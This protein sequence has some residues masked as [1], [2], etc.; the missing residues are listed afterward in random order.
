LIL[1][2]QRSLKFIEERLQ[3]ILKSSLSSAQK[4][5]AMKWMAFGRVRFLSAA[6]PFTKIFIDECTMMLKETVRKIFRLP[7]GTLRA[8]FYTQIQDG[9]LGLPDLWESLTLQKIRFWSDCMSRINVIQQ[10]LSISVFQE[11]RY[12]KIPI[13]DKPV[14]KGF[15]QWMC[16]AP[17]ER[18]SYFFNWETVDHDKDQSSFLYKRH[19]PG[20]WYW[21][22][23]APH[24][25]K[26]KLSICFT[27]ARYGATE[28]QG[29]R[30]PSKGLLLAHP[31]YQRAAFQNT[32]INGKVVDGLLQKMKTSMLDEKFKELLRIPTDKE[33]REHPM[34]GF[35]GDL[36]RSLHMTATKRR[37]QLKPGADLLRHWKP[38]MSDNTVNLMVKA[39]LNLLGNALYS[40][41]YKMN[42][43]PTCPR[44]G[45]HD[46]EWTRHIF[47]GCVSTTPQWLTRHNAVQDIFVQATQEYCS[48]LT[49]DQA[50]LHRDNR[51]PDISHAKVGDMIQIGE[52][53]V[54][55]D[56]TLAAMLKSSNMR[57]TGSPRTHVKN[58]LKMSILNWQQS[59]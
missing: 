9:G 38:S 17:V 54:P 22:T 46:L 43:G 34:T 51:R 21:F 6:M 52:F 58:S 16:V 53:T 7:Q 26:M 49:I 28:R 40:R 44:I 18:Y 42:Q 12:L 5:T 29:I 57:Q 56:D 48:D 14:P 36:W 30:M 19:S 35:Q 3:L 8:F 1:Y 4:M 10:V 27:D 59:S 45:C 15:C 55:F 31:C 50:T 37:Q 47:N 23:Q 11:A 39:R 32:A 41:V 24:L 20:R 13:E 25:L 33:L 2:K